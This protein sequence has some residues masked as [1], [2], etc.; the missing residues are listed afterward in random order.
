[1]NKSLA[2]PSPSS[3]GDPDSLVYQVQ[4]GHGWP[5]FLAAVVL[6]LGSWWVSGLLPA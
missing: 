1:M 6:T 5:L 2:N 4:E 3:F